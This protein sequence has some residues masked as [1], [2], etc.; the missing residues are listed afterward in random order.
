MTKGLATL[1]KLKPKLH[2]NVSMGTKIALP[3][4]SH[5]RWGAVLHYPSTSAALRGCTVRYMP[6]VIA[7]R[8]VQWP[9]ACKVTA[10]L[11]F[12]VISMSSNVT[13][14]S[15]RV[16]SGVKGPDALEPFM[17]LFSFRL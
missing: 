13:Y 17:C 5:C 16:R 2:I 1:G 3:K 9:S 8:A 11:T 6:H 15:L 14:P 12:M 7:A 10:H 4:E